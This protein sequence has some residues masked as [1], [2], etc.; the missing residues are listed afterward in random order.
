MKKFIIFLF[1]FV[2]LFSLFCYAQSGVA[3]NNIP[4]SVIDWLK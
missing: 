3:K 1:L 2:L 4:D